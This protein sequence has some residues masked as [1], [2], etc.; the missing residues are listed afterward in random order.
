VDNLVFCSG[1]FVIV[2]AT[3]QDFAFRINDLH[4]VPVVPAFLGGM[5]RACE[6]YGSNVLW[7]K[8]KENH[9]D[10]PYPIF[11]PEQNI[12]YILYIVNK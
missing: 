5:A 1:D 6:K 3:E 4:A 11:S 8:C 12:L 7:G 2:L 10:Y 9:S